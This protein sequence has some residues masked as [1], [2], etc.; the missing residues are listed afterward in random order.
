MGALAGALKILKLWQIGVLFGALLGAAGATYGIYTLVSD[1]GQEGLAEGQQLIPVQVGDLVNQIST[2]GSLIFPNKETLNFGTQGTVGVVLVEEGQQVEEGQPLASLDEAAVASLEK[3]VAQ[4]RVNLRNAEDALAEA[5]DPHTPLELAQAEASVANAK[6]SL[7]SAQDAL[8]SFLKPTSQDT[9][10]AEAAVVNAKISLQNAKDALD[11]FLK[12]TSQDIAQAAVAVT[13]AR[14]SVENAQELLDTVKAGPTEEDITKAQA[15]DDLASTARAVATGELSLALKEWDGKVETAREAFDT[16][17]EGYQGVFQKW[18][19]GDPGL[20]VDGDVDPDALLDSWG[21]D[22]EPLF[23]PDARFL[24]GGFQAQGPPSDDPAT[25][26]SEVTVYS[27]MNFYP[28]PIVPNCENGLVPL[29]G[30]CIKKEMDDAWDDHQQAKDNL[31]TVQIQAD[32]A[33][34]N[35]ESA[36]TMAEE[37]FAVAEEGLADVKAGPDALEIESK[38]N[39]HTLAQATLQEAE[40]ELAKLLGDSDPLEV[41]AKGKQVAV[42]QA[43]LDEGLEELA[44]LLGN[45]DPLEAET[46]EKQVAV[47]QAILDNAEEELAE[48]RGSVDPLEVALREAEATSARA[49]LEETIQRLEG[50]TL[51]APMAGIVSLVDVDAGQAV[52]ADAPVVEIVDP[53]VVEVDGIVDEIDVLFV[54]EGARAEVTMD[55]LPGQVLEGTVSAIASAARSQQGVVSY[56]ILIRVQLPDGVELREGLSATASIVIREERSVLLVPLQALYGTFE[57]PVVRVMSNGRVEERPV[58][59]GNNDDFWVAVR[60]GLA[61]GDQVVMESSGAATTQFGFGGGFRQFPG[62]LPGGGFQRGGGGGQGQ[63]R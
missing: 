12:P 45:P 24:D 47:A 53:T 38:E 48:L 16:A 14:L 20:V 17:L 22:L 40:E 34:A 58:V 10:Q 36:V 9:A 27:W 28:G 7:N 59:L 4:A 1:S 8:D 49:A 42:A 46:K 44:K 29:Q 57:Q 39:Q 51:K 32:K 5:R 2:N 30:L 31:D 19:G 26:W 6:L 55:A 61:E 54:Q 23:D 35:A 18:L 13:N 21:V 43:S 25:P 60:E 15:Q 3:A 37:S 56:P 50:A 52:T 33:I 62:A 11:S 63:R 41:E